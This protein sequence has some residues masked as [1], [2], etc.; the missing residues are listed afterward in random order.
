MTEPPS[1]QANCTCT[2]CKTLLVLQSGHATRHTGDS[3]DTATSRGTAGPSCSLR[4]AHTW[5]QGHLRSLASDAHAA[6]MEDS[7]ESKLDIQEGGLSPW[8]DTKVCLQSMAPRA[9]MTVG[10]CCMTEL[11]AGWSFPCPAHNVAAR[12]KQT[13]TSPPTNACV[14]ACFWEVPEPVKV[15]SNAYAWYLN[16]SMR[17]GV[18]AGS[19]VV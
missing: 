18:A 14:Y 19:K 3:Q 16:A 13:A 10:S 7:A 9:C 11:L 8:K 4:A 5:S 15:Q 17:G 2:N 6:V 12:T 1:S